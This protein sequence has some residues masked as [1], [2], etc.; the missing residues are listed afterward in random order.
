MDLYMYIYIYGRK[1]IDTQCGRIQKG[2]RD[3]V[4]VE[5]ERR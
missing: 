4:S 5:Y 3:E 2:G 1:E